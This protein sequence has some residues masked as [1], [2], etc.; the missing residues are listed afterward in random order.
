MTNLVKALIKRCKHRHTI[1]TH[2]KCFDEDGNPRSGSSVKLPKVL[3]FDIE[4]APL[5]AFVFQKSVWGGNVT[6][7]QVI[8]EWFMLCWS[9]KWLFN[10]NVMSARL[11]GKEAVS[12]DDSRIVKELWKLLDEADI[13]VAHNAVG[14]DVPNMN[15]RLILNGLPPTTPYQIIDT[16]QVAKRQFG[17]THNSLNALAKVFGLDPKMETDFELWKKCVD[18]DDKSLRY[19]EEYNKGDVTLLEDVYLKLRPW[20][21]AHPNLGLYVES[22]EPVCPNCGSKELTPVTDKFYYTT[23]SKYQLFRCECGAF[24]RIKTNSISKDIRKKMLVSL[25]K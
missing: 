8:S 7:D 3:I 10:D 20:I 23:T 12:E 1:L 18:G 22:S 24:G 16:K 13:V 17:F 14:F 6:D 9:A 11:T 4:T 2:P 25:G 19:M 15:T 21:K 5:R